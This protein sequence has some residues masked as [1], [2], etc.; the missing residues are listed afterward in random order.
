[1]YFTVYTPYFM[2]Y[3]T[4]N[5]KENTSLLGWAIYNV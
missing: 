2:Q 3:Y 1:M 4:D 5:K